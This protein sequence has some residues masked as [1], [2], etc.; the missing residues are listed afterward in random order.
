ML[1]VYDVTSRESFES[2]NK[3]LDDIDNSLG[4]SIVKGILANKIDKKDRKVNE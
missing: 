1:V 4:D 3:W 2:L